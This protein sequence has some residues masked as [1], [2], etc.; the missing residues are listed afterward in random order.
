MAET[1]VLENRIHLINRADRSQGNNLIKT[2]DGAQR[3]TAGSDKS[4]ERF[5]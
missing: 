1:I 5:R 4:G 2:R 3:Q